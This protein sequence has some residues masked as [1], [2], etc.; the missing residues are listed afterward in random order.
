MT[1]ALRGQELAMHRH[2]ERSFLRGVQL[3]TT[4]SAQSRRQVRSRQEQTIGLLF[5]LF[6]VD[7]SF[8]ISHTSF[9][10]G[11]PVRTDVASPIRCLSVWIVVR[12][13]LPNDNM[14]NDK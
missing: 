12:Q 13:S 7:I 14:R 2:A 10:I 1:G 11:G 5:L 3:I 4:Q 8:N 9:V 6:A